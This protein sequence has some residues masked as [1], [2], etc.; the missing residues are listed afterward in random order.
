MGKHKKNAK[1][2]RK[3]YEFDQKKKSVLFCS[4]DYFAQFE[5]FLN[6]EFKLFLK[7]KSKSFNPLVLT[8]TTVFIT[9]KIFQTNCSLYLLFENF[10]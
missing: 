2:V 3:A 6:F 5:L 8:R 1:N 4:T 9:K 7:R 10:F